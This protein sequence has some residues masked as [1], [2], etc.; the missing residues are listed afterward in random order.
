MYVIYEIKNVKTNWRYIGCSKNVSNRW[1]EHLRGLKNDNHHNIHLQRAW[2]KY[3]ESNFEFNILHEFDSEHI[4]FLREEEMI[5]DLD[6]L[7]NIAQGGLGGDVFTNHPN[8]EQYQK[9]L[10]DSSKKRFQMPGESR[11]NN[12]FLNLTPEEYEA[13]CKVWSDAARGAKNG[14]FKYDRKVKQID[15][16]TRNVVNVYDYVRLADN[17]GFNSK[18]IIHCC[19][20]KEGFHSHKGYIWEWV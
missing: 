18:Y 13:R 16:K 12:V 5:N 8:K 7:Y 15:K 9:R 19:N 6:M 4:M 3:G 2:N 11:K 1:K 17:D 20:K 10:S 14:R